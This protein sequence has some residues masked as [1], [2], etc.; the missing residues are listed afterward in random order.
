MRG[1][2][3]CNIGAARA[4]R[5]RDRRD[6]CMALPQCDRALAK[7]PG[8]VPASQHFAE[9]LNGPT[10]TFDALRAWCT[11]AKMY[12]KYSLQICTYLSLCYRFCITYPLR[13]A[14][15]HKVEPKIW[16]RGSVPPSPKTARACCKCSA[17]ATWDE[18][19]T[20]RSFLNVTSLLKPPFPPTSPLSLQ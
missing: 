2:L 16:L 20:K 3:T 19:I 14:C 15:L 6:A 10:F 13:M 18:M 7:C 12:C 8:E 5:L 17:R 1:F 11:S 4:H 9:S